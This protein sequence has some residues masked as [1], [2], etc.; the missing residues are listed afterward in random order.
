MPNLD[1]CCSSGA[2]RS[3][4]KLVRKYMSA[5]VK[6]NDRIEICRY[7]DFFKQPRKVQTELGL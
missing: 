4:C 1:K 6:I 3:K 7:N 5:L 2:C